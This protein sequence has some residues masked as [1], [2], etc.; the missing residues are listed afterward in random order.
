MTYL[1][2]PRASHEISQQL[3][4]FNA[5][6]A[7]AVYSTTLSVRLRVVHGLGQPVYWVRFGWI[8]IFFSV[9][10]VGSW[11]RSGR[12][13][14]KSH[15]LTTSVVDTDG[16]GVDLS[17]RISQFYASACV[18]D[19]MR[20]S[21]ISCNKRFVFSA[22]CN[23]YISRLC[24]DVS[25]RLSVRLSVTEV[26]WRIIANLGFKFRSQFTAHC[27]RRPCC[28]PCCLRVDHLAPC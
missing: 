17:R 11:V 1:I 4:S 28:S 6:D 23:I 10:W 25:I 19:V 12:N 21:C 3:K 27:G 9:G 20:L 13:W 5:V 15:S 24:Y 26:H 18:C 16:Q 14:K 2:M 8:E 7:S 22:R